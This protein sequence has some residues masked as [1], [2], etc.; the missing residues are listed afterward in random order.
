V[1]RAGFVIATVALVVLAGS[2]TA[3]DFPVKEPPPAILAAYDWSG[4]YAGGHIGY[5]WGASDWSTPGNTGALNLSQ[6]VDVFAETGSFFEGFHA[7]YNYMLPN[8]I[9][10]GVEADT[11]FPA[12]RNL[13]GLSIGGSTTFF[14][15]IAGA[16]ETYSETMLASGT[17]RGRI[18]Y[19]PGN[20]LFYATGVHGPTIS[21][22]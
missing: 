19:A 5:A 1:T 15:P 17:V 4:F 12:F 18:G 14:S 6:P 20:W 21:L 11:T 8:R 16:L 10:V 2:A 22:R 7:G 13:N 9:V 3:A